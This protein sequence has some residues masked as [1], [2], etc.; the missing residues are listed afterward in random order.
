MARIGTSNFRHSTKTDERHDASWREIVTLEDGVNGSH[1]YAGK[2]TSFC[3]LAKGSEVPKWSTTNAQ[4]QRSAVEGGGAPLPPAGKPSPYLARVSKPSVGVVVWNDMVAGTV[5][6]KSIS[7][8]HKRPSDAEQLAPPG[9]FFNLPNLV[10][11]LD[12]TIPMVNYTGSCIAM[13]LL[14]ELLPNYGPVSSSTQLP[15]M[16]LLITQPPDGVLATFV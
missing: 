9:V 10:A 16:S 1:R 6:Q 14:R 3:E 5:K 8:D 2:A 4:F 13:N 15:A 7:C 12:Q 11:T